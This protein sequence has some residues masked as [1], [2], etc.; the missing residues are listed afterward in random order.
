MK[1]A[2]VSGASSGMG[3]EFAK[4]IPIHFHELDEIWVISRRKEYL[5]SLSAN[6]LEAKIR[7]I[8][9]SLT[10]KEDMD[11]FV[12]LLSDTKPNIKVL[13]NSAGVGYLSQF[14]SGEL[15]IWDNMVDLNCKALMEMCHICIP[16]MEKK[17]AII[18][19][20][21]A[22]AFCPQAGT[23]VYAASKA[24]VYSFSRAL[25]YELKDLGIHVTTVCPGPVKT[26]FFTIA[27]PDNKTSTIKKLCMAKTEKVVSK[28]LRDCKNKREMSVYGVSMKL[29]RIFSK[30]LPDSLLIKILG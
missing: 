2:I 13:V 20:A 26:D 21:S 18:N 28:A 9:M 4:Q 1:I 15:S 24:F 17:S 14:V 6:V 10:N 11:F 29:T 23:N 30:I 25:N 3:R 5:T 7:D 19:I 12:K 27:D 16:Y 8:P 22:S